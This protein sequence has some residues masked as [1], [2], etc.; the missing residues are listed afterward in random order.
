MAY[1]S[2]RSLRMLQEMGSSCGEECTR[3]GDPVDACGLGIYDL[4]GGQGHDG[5]LLISTGKRVREAYGIFKAVNNGN[6]GKGKL[7]V[8]GV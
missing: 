2:R 6:D 4:C 5:R 1:I 8:S 7:P 3:S